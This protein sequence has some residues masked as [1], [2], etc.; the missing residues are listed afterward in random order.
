MRAKNAQ[1]RVH[2][3]HTRKQF[4]I[5]FPLIGKSEMKYAMLKMSI[6]CSNKK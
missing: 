6:K 3:A 2:A 1:M 4:E 5:H